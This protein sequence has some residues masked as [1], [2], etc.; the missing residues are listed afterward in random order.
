MGNGLMGRETWV[1]GEGAR[2][3]GETG[4]I[5]QRMYQGAY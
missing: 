1:P 5:D 4:T 2:M 3:W